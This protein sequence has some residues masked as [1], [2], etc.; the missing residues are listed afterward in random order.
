MREYR[1]SA[2][3]VYALDYHF[4]CITKYRKAILGGE[5][6]TEVRDLIREICRSHDIEVLEGHMHPDI[7]ICC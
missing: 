7:S 1:R 4:V 5:I 3:T 6:R 2:H